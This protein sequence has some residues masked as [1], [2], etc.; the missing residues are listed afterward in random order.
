MSAAC[1]KTSLE[2][3]AWSDRSS[4][5][6]ST[7]FASSWKASEAEM[8]SV[9]KFKNCFLHGLA[10]LFYLFLQ[11]VRVSCWHETCMECV[12]QPYH[13]VA[14]GELFGKGHMLSI[15]LVFCPGSPRNIC[16]K[17]LGTHLRIASFP[18]YQ[19]HVLR[20]AWVIQQHAMSG[21]PL[22]TDRY[23][24]AGCSVHADAL[25]CC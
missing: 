8:P 9:K 1:G 22:L 3:I 14:F 24:V 18:L 2:I 16:C 15:R 17:R 19:G 21:G 4:L 10:K 5:E 6:A 7:S 20:M 11:A 23:R 12:G 25:L 13:N